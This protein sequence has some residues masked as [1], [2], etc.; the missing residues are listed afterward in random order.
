MPR[1]LRRAARRAP[2]AERYQTVPKESERDA[3]LARRENARA[4]ALMDKGDDA[5]A[6]VALKAALDADVMCGPAHN[7]L[8]KVYYRQGKFYPAA[9]E[10]QFAMKLMPNQP[11]PPNNLGL[12]FEAAG[13]LDEAAE[14]Y[15]KAVALEPGNVQAMGNLARAR[16][17]RGDRDEEVR[18]LLTQLVLRDTRPDWLA[19]EKGTLSRARARRPRRTQPD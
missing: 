12:V 5:A 8:G 18:A 9:L 1:G 10:F 11:E 2:R 7:N 3:D 17:R 13:K 14:S 4:A 16:Y 6:E 15:G 19:W